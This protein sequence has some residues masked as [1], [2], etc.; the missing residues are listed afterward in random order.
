[1]SDELAE[2]EEELA[3]GDEESGTSSDDN[4]KDRRNPLTA[5]VRHHNVS[6]CVSHWT[7]LVH[8]T[9]AECACVCKLCV[10]KPIF[11]I[12]CACIY[13]HM[14]G[15]CAHKLGDCAHM[16]GA[17]T[18][19]LGGCAHMLGACILTSWVV[20]L[21]CCAVVLTSWVVQASPILI[22]TF[23]ITFVAEWGDRSQ[24]TL[25]QCAAAVLQ[26]SHCSAHRLQHTARHTVFN[27]LT[28][29]VACTEFKCCCCRLPPSHWL[30]PRMS[31]E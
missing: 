18:H 21:T 16:L 29:T 4:S 1:M 23:T 11:S 28:Q 26:H 5:L 15:S 17:C 20:V 13:T 14:L 9:V 2:T 7:L 22:K 31:M 6:R 27:A 3:E 19:K 10:H 25:S 24:V 8:A 12:F 30:R